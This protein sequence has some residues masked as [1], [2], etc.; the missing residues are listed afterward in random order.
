MDLETCSVCLVETE[1]EALTDTNYGNVCS[2]CLDE[3][4]GNL[5]PDDFAEEMFS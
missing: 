4:S 5:S 1:W 2:E 3:I